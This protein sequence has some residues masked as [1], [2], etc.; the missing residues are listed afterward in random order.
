[1]KKRFSIR[2]KLIIIF[3]ALV[4]AA[5]FIAGFISVNVARK[6]VMQRIEIQLKKEA[7]YVGEIVTND[8]EQTVKYLEAI[9]RTPLL[10][11]SQVS[12]EEKTALLLKEASST[13]AKQ[14]F[15]ADTKGNKYTIKGKDFS[16]ADREYF[17]EAMAGNQY[18]T[19]PL[20]S[21]VTGELIT[22][23]SVPLYD[24]SK[25]IIGV[26]YGVYDGLALNQFIKD[27]KVGD[28]GEC[29]ILDEK[30]TFIAYSD[31]EK[32]YEQYN[33]IEHAK[34]DQTLSSLANFIE[35]ALAS[36][37]SE[38]GY[39]D[40]KDVSFIASNHK[41]P[42]TG[43]T[44]IIRAPSH[45]F[46]ESVLTLR[47]T[48]IGVGLGM[49]I[50]VL[51]VIFFVALRIVRP[52]NVV[53]NALRNIAQGDGDLTVRLPRVGNDEVTDLSEYFN[54]TIEKINLSIKSVMDGTSDMSKVG[55]TLSNNMTATASSIN[56][57][58]ANIEGVKGQILNQSAGVIETSATMDEIIR[59]I[60]SLD[61]RIANQ[62]NTLRE[63]IKIIND[64]DQT[65]LETRNILHKND[66]LIAELV[67]TSSEGKSVVTASEQEVNKILEESGTLMDAST[68]IQNIASQTNLLAMNAAIEAA[69]AG[70]AGKGFAVVA[71]EIRKLAEESSSQA[72]MITAS[73]K[74]LST[75]IETVSQSSNDI[76][77]NF[78]SIFSKIN[79]VK[80]RSAGIMRIAQTRKEQSAKLLSL[81][82]SVDGITN[83]VK[84]GSAEML[85]GGEQVAGEMQKLEDLTRIIT[86]SMNE[87][88]AG[89]AQIN[90]AVQEVNE[91]SN[92][93]QKSIES[94]AEEVHKFKV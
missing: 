66:E 36:T 33:I 88:A 89:A 85:K 42:A 49:W 21:R 67:T 18:I 28:T 26:I 20:K 62:I 76:G 78:M 44:V 63:L 55:Q 81:V 19:K 13:D 56:Q 24:N 84:D 59:T 15:I 23:I 22:I 69:H 45:E 40:Y 7:G 11:D 92:Q 39:Y 46:L 38:I 87:M 1:M 6:A 48:L 58:S 16:I 90:N 64:S 74:N 94:L 71:D 27:V 83:E 35:T 53:V 25:K 73:L 34:T 31:K 10:R 86:D 91:M 17:K 2:N 47:K 75:E 79:E 70:D 54:R 43:W 80:E 8:I 14:L 3:G 37:E 30:G 57:I 5:L 4:F 68:I 60:H 72:K 9:A 41:M 32:V 12:Y 50:T 51:I 65:T 93:N 82:E 29:Y 77:E 52:I 61:S